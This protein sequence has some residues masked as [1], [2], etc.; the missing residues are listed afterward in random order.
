MLRCGILLPILFSF[1][2]YACKSKIL[3]VAKN[4]V[5]FYVQNTFDKQL[6]NC[7]LINQKDANFKPLSLSGVESG[8]KTWDNYE[9]DDIWM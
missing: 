6:K 9:I 7:K 3:D 2:V 8:L 1:W 5:C 4:L